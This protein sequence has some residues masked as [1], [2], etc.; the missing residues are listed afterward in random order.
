MVHGKKE[1]T[2]EQKQRKAALEAEV[3]ELQEKKAELPR[4]GKLF[5]A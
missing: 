4:L 3:K 2:E 5:A 1:L